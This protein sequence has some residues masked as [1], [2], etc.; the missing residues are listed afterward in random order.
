MCGLSIHPNSTNG[1]DIDW[2]SFGWYLCTFH[3][4]GI[5]LICINALTIPM[6]TL[7][8]YLSLG[9]GT[10]NVTTYP[11]PDKASLT[12]PYQCIN[13]NGDLSKCNKDRCDGKWKPPRTHHCS[14]CGVCRLEFDHHC[15][16]VGNCVT[17][18]RLK[19]F[20]SLLYLVPIAFAIGILPVTK[21]L[22][23][24]IIQALLVSKEDEWANRIWWNWLGSWIVCAGP[25][26]RWIVGTLL[27]FVRL[28]EVR[29]PRNPT[30]HGYLIE[31]PHLRV[32]ITSILA[33]LLSVFALGLAIVS[34]RKILQGL[35]TLESIKSASHR[36]A[37]GHH[38][39]C[40]PLERNPHASVSE[41]V[42]RR[43][44]YVAA[45]L[46]KERI[47]DLGPECNWRTFKSRPLF[48]TDV[49]SSYI[50]P[51][52]NPGMLQRLRTMQANTQN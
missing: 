37:S 31:E 18:S 43:L 13:E 27:G 7:Y 47:Y 39:I 51:K 11:L 28:R 14:T 44:R 21:I 25:F 23:G 32:I 22:H 19:A 30:S 38:M 29:R 3:I 45:V 41:N 20:M 16:W 42:D 8:V 49:H 46:A 40:V 9:R 24:H 52:L 15:P 50:W 2:R 12:E 4:G 17:I 1:I 10:H 33:L 34:T 48:S 6:A 26:G 35:T 36:P 5:Y